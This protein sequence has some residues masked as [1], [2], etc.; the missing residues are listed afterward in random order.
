[1]MNIFDLE[2][3]E[4]KKAVPSAR[5]KKNGSKS[6]KCKLSTDGLTERQLQKRNG[7]IVTYKLNRPM[8]W[9]EFKAMP[10]DIQEKYLMDLKDRF[11]IT[12][13]AVSRM[14]GVTGQSVIN[15]LAKEEYSIQLCKGQSMTK[16]QKWAFESFIRGNT[17][18]NKVDTVGNDTEAVVVNVEDAPLVEKVESNPFQMSEFSMSMNGKFNRETFF[19]SLAMMIPD[20]VEV[21]MEIKCTFNKFKE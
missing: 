17:Q 12:P 15:L 13:T 14:F 11:G 7:A 19:R 6:K 16:E 9:A 20:G 8:Q 3:Y 18:E 2:V 1:M 5:H 10:V 4:K 21:N